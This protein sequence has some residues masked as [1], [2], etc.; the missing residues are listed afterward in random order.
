LLFVRA[1]LFP[2]PEPPRRFAGLGGSSVR[3]RV[4]RVGEESVGY[5]WVFVPMCSAA[6]SLRTTSFCEPHTKIQSMTCRSKKETN[7]K[8]NHGRADGKEQKPSREGRPQSNEKRST[9]FPRTSGGARGTTLRPPLPGRR[10]RP[11]RRALKGR[12]RSQTKLALN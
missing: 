1:A 9:R 8:T 5:M 6:C 4:F 10:G 3:P 12:S 11:K 7:N 2:T